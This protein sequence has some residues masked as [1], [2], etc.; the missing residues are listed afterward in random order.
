MQADSYLKQANVVS[1]VKRSALVVKAVTTAL[2]TTPLELSV[3][4]A[5]KDDGWW[6]NHRAANR[7]AAGIIGE[8][9]GMVRGLVLGGSIVGAALVSTRIV[10]QPMEKLAVGAAVGTAVAAATWLRGLWTR[11]NS[12]LGRT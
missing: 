12:L 8:G 7:F 4:Q 9:D 1:A 3:M 10:S 6:N 2:A 5:A 11:P